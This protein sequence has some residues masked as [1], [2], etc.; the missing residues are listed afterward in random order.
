MRNDEN[1][2]TYHLTFDDAVEVWLRYWDGE[3]QHSIAAH[4]R[5]NQGRISE[6]LSGK[7]HPGSRGAAAKHRK[8]A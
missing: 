2:P 5:V 1:P 7:L 4:F 6:V 3:Y 8:A